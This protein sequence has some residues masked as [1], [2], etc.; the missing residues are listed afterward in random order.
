LIYVSV[1]LVF[2]VVDLTGTEV[3]LIGVYLTGI[4]LVFPGIFYFNGIVD[5][6]VVAVTG[7]DYGFSYS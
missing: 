2:V 6:V 7:L 4:E 1:I 3:Y 5:L